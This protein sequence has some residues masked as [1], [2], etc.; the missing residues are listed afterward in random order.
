MKI[1]DVNE[2]AAIPFCTECKW[3]YR[4]FGDLIWGH[5][6]GKCGRPVPNSMT[7]EVDLVT[8]KIR[9]SNKQG[10]IRHADVQRKFELGDSCGEQA[11][12]FV[13]K[14]ENGLIKALSRKI[15]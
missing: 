10:E 8:G 5:R 1:K 12:H 3:Y 2:A 7:Y 9:T 6:F 14:T 11:K 15:F 4:D 13:P